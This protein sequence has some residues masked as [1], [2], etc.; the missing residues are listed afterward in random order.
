MRSYE[1]PSESLRQGFTLIELLVV[2]AIIA[3]LAAMLLPSLNRA[4]ARAQTTQCLNNLKQLQL[5]WHLYALDNNGTIVPNKA[6]SPDSTTEPDSWIAGS[7]KL[8]ETATNIQ[9]AAFYPYNSAIAIYHC[10]SDKSCVTGKA[11]PRFR[12]YGMSYPYMNGDINPTFKVF[13]KETEILE[14]GPSVA[15][16]LWGE[17]EDSID[18]GGF[19]IAPPG[20]WKWENWPASR[21]NKGGTV[22]FADGHVEYWRWRGP[23]VF[24]FSG[25]GFPATP[26]D[27]DLVRMHKTVGKL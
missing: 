13:R 3:I 9:R 1:S 24:S 20:V 6:Q 5:C 26:N 11:L 19:Y 10:P 16:V 2:I 22:S 15:S 21:H 8:D 7:A 25:Y 14:P 17:N 4:K 18:N 12:S 27:P 23:T